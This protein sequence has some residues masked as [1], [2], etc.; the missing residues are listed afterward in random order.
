MGT[1]K[2]R[3]LE[4]LLGECID[5]LNILLTEG[6]IINGIRYSLSVKCFIAD[7]P[8]RALLK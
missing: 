3:N 1:Q 8:A 6:I 2:P 5:E 7:T 4:L